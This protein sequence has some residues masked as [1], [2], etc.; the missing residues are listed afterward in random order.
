MVSKMCV[1]GL[2]TPTLALMSGTFQLMG[3]VSFGFGAK[4]Y[5][6]FGVEPSGT[7]GDAKK[8]EY[9]WLVQFIGSFGAILGAVLTLFFLP[10]GKQNEDLEDSS[11]DCSMT[12]G[13]V[14]ESC[15]ASKA[16]TVSKSAC[17]VDVTSV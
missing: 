15:V 13:S 8:F 2:E 5:E 11:A 4:L 17:V 6:A 9:Y 3:S 16:A 7:I 1:R 12:E 14:W 10:K